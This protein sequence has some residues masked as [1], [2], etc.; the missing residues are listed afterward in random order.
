MTMIDAL[1]EMYSKPKAGGVFYSANVGTHLLEKCCHDMDIAL[2]LTESLPARVAVLADMR[3][4]LARWMQETRDPVLT[5]RIEPTPGM[6]V[7]CG[8]KDLSH[9]QPVP[10][11][12]IVVED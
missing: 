1:R 10:A 11:E 12:P 7:N 9:G 6:L 2:W 5:G 8:E 4:R 3:A